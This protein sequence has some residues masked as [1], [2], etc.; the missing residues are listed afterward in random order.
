MTK[1]EAIKYFSEGIDCSQVVFGYGAEKTGFSK[2]RALKISSP[3]GGGIWHG[4]TCSCVTGALMAIGLK[5]GNCMPGDDERKNRMLDK[6]NEFEQK[7]KS[8]YGSCICRD[9]LKYD[10]SIPEELEI[11]TEK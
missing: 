7:F 11:I 9:I 1:E 5:Y 3:F 2:E 4:D 6:K 8:K 10:I